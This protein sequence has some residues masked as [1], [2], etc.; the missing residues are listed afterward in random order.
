MRLFG[1]GL[2]WGTPLTNA[3]GAAIANPSPLL[4]GTLQDCEVE[5]KFEIKKLHGQLQ[6]PVE[7]T[8]G[9]GSITFKAKAADIYGGYLE[10]I[11]F[12][13]A[14]SAGLV[15]AVYDTVGTAVPAT[16][17]QITV[18]PP[19]SGVFAADLGVIDSTTGRPLTRVASA[20]ATGQYSVTVGGQYTFAAADTAKVFYINYRYTA[21]SAVARKGTIANLPMGYAPTFRA[22]LYVPYAGGSMIFTF[23]RAITDGMKFG[24]KNDDFT[25]PE[26]GGEFFADVAG[27]LGTWSTTE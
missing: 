26:F 7:A 6:F 8:R 17:Y 21:T 27:N 3:A 13:Q 14:G 19:A 1:S 15:S 5:A 9:K 16:P 24:F 4:F 18:T 12:G 25:I 20:P 23:N 11:V 2:L 10:T 22:D